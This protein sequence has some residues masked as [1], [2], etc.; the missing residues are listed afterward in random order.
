MIY[1]A[2]SKTNIIID[3]FIIND[4]KQPLNN[5]NIDKIV[6]HKEVIQIVILHFKIHLII[7]LNKIKD[8]NIM[9]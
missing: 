9:N 7:Y 6:S 8:F 3:F 1:Q 4:Q 2:W 5:E